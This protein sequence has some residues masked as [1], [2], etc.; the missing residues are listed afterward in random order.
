MKN[1][2]AFLYQVDQIRKLEDFIIKNLEISASRLMEK[3]GAA[4]FKVLKCRWPKAKKI[5][6]VCGKGNNGG[7]GYVL[8][9]LAKKAKLEVKILHLAP[10]SSLKNE[11]KIA[12]LKCQK[13]KIEIKKFS[14]RAL[15]GSDL[16]V[17][18][19]FGIG[20]RGNMGEDFKKAVKDINTSKIPV[21]SIDIPSGIDGDTGENLN[22]AI[23]AKV[24]ITF[25]ANKIG[26]FVGDARNNTGEIICDDLKLSKSI[27]KLV[28]HKVQILDLSN[29][30]K[31]LKPRKRNSHKG[32]F[33]HVLVIGGD[34]GM[35]GAVLM[36]ATAAAR[37][38]T[39]LVSIAT[40]NKHIS[41]INYRQPEFMVYD[42]DKVK[43]L[44]PLL[45]KGTVILVGP[46]L[47]QS[48]WAKKIFN[49]A[50]ES[51]KPMV[52]DA[53][54]LN[55]L[56]K[57]CKHNENWILT[58][59]PGEAV[60][61]LGSEGAKSCVRCQMPEVLQK[62]F[63]GVVVL[64]GSGT[65]ITGDKPPM[66]ICDA[67][68]PGMAS[69]GMGDVLGGLIAGILAQISG[70][71]R[72]RLMKQK[73]LISNNLAAAKLAVLLHAVAGDRVASNEGCLGMF[74][75]DLLKEIRNILN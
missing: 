30:M 21:L 39:G 63:G 17:D 4:A 42:V 59:H 13:L 7:D 10:Y 12:A 51:K 45:K 5:T 38:G 43:Q 65:L 32:D 75:T 73:S 41:D 67:G 47:G 44:E 28:K 46:G 31:L 55:L 19:I 50:L 58:P 48:S 52:I 35:G 71:V 23:E 33:G 56:A 24:T 26:L 64:K 22:G 29:E 49:A 14:K 62:K 40:R 74:A 36:A 27:F 2:S 16:V 1:N 72:G 25:I 53:D 57:T 54:G 20:L 3:A 15:K 34:Y 66:F 18:A 6:V 60:R 11:A 70:S 69:A 9:R 8:A 68:N 61:L 37:V